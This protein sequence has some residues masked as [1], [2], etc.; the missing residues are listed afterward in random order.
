MYYLD[1]EFELLTC[2]VG[3]I[4]TIFNKVVATI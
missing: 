4:A 1:T 2:A 3:V